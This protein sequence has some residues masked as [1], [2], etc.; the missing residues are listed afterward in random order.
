MFALPGRP[1]TS[2]SAKPGQ[3]LVQGL[4]AVQSVQN[5]WNDWNFWNGWNE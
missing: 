5:V 3:E 4:Q 2:D 1:E